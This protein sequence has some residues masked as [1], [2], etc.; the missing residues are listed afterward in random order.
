MTKPRPARLAAFFLWALAALSATFWFTQLSGTSHHAG[1][2]VTLAPDVP[3]VQTAD[4]A[5]VFGPPGMPTA[6]M[7]AALNPVVNAAA[8][9]RLIG[10]VAN[11]AHTGVALI[12]VDGQT[13]RPYRVGSVLEGGWKL[14][15]VD[16]RSATLTTAE[17]AA[18]PVTIE[19]APRTAA[20]IGGAASVLAPAP[21]Q[22]TGMAPP[23][24]PAMAVPAI[25]AAAGDDDN[26]TRK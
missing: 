9:L 22:V 10:V 5:R 13:P 8:R 2:A 6:N 14:Q 20:P 23:A 21:P 17:S 3:V 18:A 24:G 7:P 11:R 4:L 1:S 19:L 15:K 12:S 25:P 26:A 16:T